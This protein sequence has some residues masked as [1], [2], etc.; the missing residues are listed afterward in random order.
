MDFNGLTYDASSGLYYDAA[1]NGYDDSGTQWVAGSGSAVPTSTANG[2]APSTTWLTSIL[3]TGLNAYSAIIGKK[4]ATTTP[5]TTTSQ[6][7]IIWVVVGV[8]ALALVLMLA[9]KD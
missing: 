6:S 4:P 5:T 7:W 3:N 9:R 1:G 2:N 8:A